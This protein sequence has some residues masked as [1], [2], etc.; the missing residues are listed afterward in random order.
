MLIKYN[1]LHQ[2]IKIYY[3]LRNKKNEI[4][5]KLCRLLFLD[6]IHFNFEIMENK[7]LKF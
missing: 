2:F 6:T 7:I 5:L 3:F 1:F 4:M